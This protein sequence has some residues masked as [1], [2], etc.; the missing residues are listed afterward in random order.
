MP[1]S[2]STPGSPD[3]AVDTAAIIVAG[4]EGH[5]FGGLKQYSDLRGTRVLDHSIGAARAVADFVVLVVPERLVDRPE[6]GVDAVVAGGTSRSASV[7][8]GLAVVPESCTVVI[9][10]D[11]VRP[12][13]SVELFG[14]VV[15]TVRGGA[16][17]A[18]P[19]V[20]VVD[21]LRRRDGVPLAV[22]RDDLVAVQTPQAFRADALRSVHAAGD[23]EATDDA[24]LVTAAGGSVVVVPGERANVKITD[25]VDLRIVE[26]LAADVTRPAGVGRRSGAEVTR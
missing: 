14:Q 26:A 16:D 15:A 3:R 2:Q 18:I 22:G 4:G 25:A 9:V 6:P 10:H 24:S 11:A 23:A 1:D 13:A 21:T 19:G 8:S 20:A 12:L 5:R 17:G 7:R